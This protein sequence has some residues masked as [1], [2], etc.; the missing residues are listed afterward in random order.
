M[1]RTGSGEFY[2]AEP[3]RVEVILREPSYI[4][5]IVGLVTVK[6]S[7]EVLQKTT[8]MSESGMIR[9][10]TAEM[11]PPRLYVRGSS[12]KSNT[13]DRRRFRRRT[14]R[15]ALCFAVNLRPSPADNMPP[16]NRS[17]SCNCVGRGRPGKKNRERG[18]AHAG[19]WPGG[20][21]GGEDI[22]YLMRASD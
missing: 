15:D 9:S 17:S 12:V 2:G 14:A 7:H 19:G 22:L 4:R 21:V 5:A 16:E 11:I 8:T 20:R 6:S 18:T 3:P 13:F 10:K 1:W